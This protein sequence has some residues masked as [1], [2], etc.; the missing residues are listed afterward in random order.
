MQR[1]QEQYKNT[2]IHTRKYVLN[3]TFI[4]ILPEVGKQNKTQTTDPLIH[5]LFLAP[6]GQEKWKGKIIKKER[7]LKY[8]DTHGDRGIK[9]NKILKYNK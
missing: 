3:A 7:T 2:C 5:F 1:K 4:H 9:E 6:N 8:K